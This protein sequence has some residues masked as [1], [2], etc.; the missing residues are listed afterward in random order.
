MLCS[1]FQCTKR[2][3]PAN[4]S[5]SGN[6]CR[7]LWWSLLT[8]L[9]TISSSS[10]HNFNRDDWQML[11]NWSCSN[12][13]CYLSEMGLSMAQWLPSVR[14]QGYLLTLADA[15]LCDPLTVPRDMSSISQYMKLYQFLF[16]CMT[17]Q[18]KLNIYQNNVSCTEFSAPLRQTY[19]R[20][21]SVYMVN[22]KHLPR[23][24][25]FVCLTSIWQRV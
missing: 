1:H 10:P 4:L 2:C 16:V 3:F 17:V 13:T 11:P 7:Y 20:L 5:L 6:S 18:M 19:S 14:P 24:A 12:E 8:Q 25:G 22:W 23:I 21:E 15:V 9:V